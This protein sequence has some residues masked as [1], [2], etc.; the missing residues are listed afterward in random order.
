MIE[1]TQYQKMDFRYS[2]CDVEVFGLVSKFIKSDDNGN[3]MIHD[4]ESGLLER[5][6]STGHEGAAKRIDCWKGDI[7]HIVTAGADGTCRIF[8]FESGKYLRRAQGHEGP[9]NCLKLSEDE[10]IRKALIATGGRDHTVR[11]FYLCSGRL[12]NT[13]EGHKHP[14]IAVD[15]L[16]TMGGYEVVCSCDITGEIRL[17]NREDGML[18][19]TFEGAYKDELALIAEVERKRKLRY[20]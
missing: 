20:G 2:R 4:T 13:M 12:R 15:F 17:W 8:N 19:R 7:V 14:I 18:M 6:I 5:L 1:K 10:D 16:T 11:L 9:V 3:I